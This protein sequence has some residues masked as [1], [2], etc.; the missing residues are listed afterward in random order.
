MGRSLKTMLR[1]RDENARAF[2]LIELLVVVAIIAILAALLL[3]ALGNAKEQARRI[4]CANNQ[5]Q[6][7]YTYELYSTD[8]SMA[9]P[10]NGHPLGILPPGVTLWFS[11]THGNLETRTNSMYITDPKYASFA[12]YLK[13]A[14]PYKCPSDRQSVT[15]IIGGTVQN[16]VTRRIPVTYSYA[17]NGY[18]NPVGIVSNIWGPTNNKLY[19]RVNDIESPSDRLVFVEGNP[20]S[21]CCPAF[22]I[23][24]ESGNEFFHVPSAVHRKGGLVSFADGHT[25]FKR[26]LDPRTNM[27][28]PGDAHF[29]LAHVSSPNNKDLRWLQ[30]HA[31]QRK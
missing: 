2:T 9:L 19:L 15:R 6:L 8:N 30:A 25:E 3:A 28:L 20:Q 31:S 26:W 7:A 5:K 29:A 24:P 13:T 17:M 4:I 12:A 23:Y 14:T 21:L 11:A 22:M 27:K 16:P 1:K 18:F 10:Y